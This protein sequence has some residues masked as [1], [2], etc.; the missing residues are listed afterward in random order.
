VGESSIRRKSRKSATAE[1]PESK[2]DNQ[3]ARSETSAVLAD[4]ADSSSRKDS[5]QAE[6]QA[7][8]IEWLAKQGQAGE[9]LH[10]A[11]HAARDMPEF[12]PRII[13]GSMFLPHPDTARR[14]GKDPAETLRL[15]DAAGWIETDMRA[16]MRK[17]E[18][19]SVPNTVLDW[20]VAMNPGL[21]R[22]RLII[23]LHRHPEAQLQGH[24]LL[25][26]R[27]DAAG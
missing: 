11:I 19:L 27:K 26:A 3:P 4:E 21:T 20:Y 25:I 24:T 17:P 18:W 5:Q 13:N 8:A 7:Q 1:T 22:S 10:A 12:A 14:L 23:A 16:P 6:L 2:P 15:L 9:W